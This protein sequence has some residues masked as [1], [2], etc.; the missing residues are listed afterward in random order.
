MEIYTYSCTYLLFSSLLGIGIRGTNPGI[1]IPTSVVSVQ[2]RTKKL[3]ECVALFQH[4]S[5]SGIMSLLNTP[6]PESSNARRLGNSGIKKTLIRL[7]PRSQLH[8]RIVPCQIHIA[9]Y[10]VVGT[11]SAAA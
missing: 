2:Y 11:V 4:Y 5:S 1:G 9:F 6:I 10:C 8:K 7:V 3:L